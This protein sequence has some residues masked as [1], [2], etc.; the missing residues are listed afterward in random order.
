[1]ATAAELQDAVAAEIVRYG[2]LEK[3]ITGLSND[4]CGATWGAPVHDILKAA[5]A[6]RSRRAK[7][8]QQKAA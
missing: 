1:M 8:V 2:T 6:E 5:L 3:A 4:S 7:A